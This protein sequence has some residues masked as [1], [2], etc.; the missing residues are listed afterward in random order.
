MSDHEKPDWFQDREQR[1]QQ[2]KELARQIREN[3]DIPIEERIK[4][5]KALTADIE[6]DHSR[7]TKAEK[8][9]KLEELRKKHGNLPKTVL[10]L[11][12][13]GTIL[14]NLRTFSQ[15]MR[16]ALKQDLS[17]AIILGDV[18]QV[19]RLIASGADVNGQ[20]AAGYSLLM[21]AGI[22]KQEEIVQLLRQ[23][24]AKVGIHEAALLGDM[25]TLQ[26]LLEGGADVNAR[27][28]KGFTAL[29]WAASRGN[30][31]AVKL[32]LAWGANVDNAGEKGHTPLLSA[33]LLNHTEVAA[34]LVD[35]GAAVGVVETALLGDRSLLAQLLEVGADIESENTACMTPLMAA[36]AS[37]HNDCIRLLLD[38]GANLHRVNIRHFSA[39]TWAINYDRRETV[40]LLLEAGMD[41]NAPDQ[42][43][44]EY[45]RGGTPIRH[46]IMHRLP[47]M[48]R[49]LIAHGA[50]M[51]VRDVRGQTPL[52]WAAMTCNPDVMR[53]LLDAGADVHAVGALQ[54]TPLMRVVDHI[55]VKKES[56]LACVRLLIERGADVNARAEHGKT[57]LMMATG[58]GHIEIMRLLLDAGSDIEAKDEYG[59]TAL[60]LA[61]TGLDGSVEA[62]ALLKK[63]GARVNMAENIFGAVLFGRTDVLKALLLP[64]FWKRKR[65]QN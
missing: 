56:H 24:G 45:L 31:E 11:K 9:R 44:S 41:V 48:T 38:R 52:H 29:N 15:E 37:G 16:S 6:Q 7:P 62:V 34:L 5:L 8:E 12:E 22:Q 46:A 58:R 32:L 14:K 63:Y 43:E 59:F 50:T 2:L 20:S 36:A 39:L 23:A 25:D 54:Y 40:P 33:A 53:V 35:S 19:S 3:S 51:D 57:A 13:I 61:S 10:I 30:M 47:E 4:R 60:A 26:A 28:K 21:L 55:L 18:L 27:D 17:G 42:H 64:R 1:L 49:L 65:T